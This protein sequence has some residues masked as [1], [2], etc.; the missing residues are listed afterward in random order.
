MRVGYT[1]GNNIGDEGCRGMA[2]LIEMR[3]ANISTAAL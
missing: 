3:T 2:S 1:D